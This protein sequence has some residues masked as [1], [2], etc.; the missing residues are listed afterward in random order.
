MQKKGRIIKPKFQHGRIVVCERTF[1]PMATPTSLTGMALLGIM[2]RPKD[3]EE[4]NNFIFC[5]GF[6]QAMYSRDI[7]GRIDITNHSQHAIF[8]IEVK[9]HERSKGYGTVLMNAGADHCRRAGVTTMTGEFGMAGQVDKRERFYERL[10]MPVKDLVLP[11]IS[12]NVNN[13]KLNTIKFEHDKNATEILNS[14]PEL[15]RFT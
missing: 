11:T 13:P 5:E 3:E 10:D 14:I 8:N 4:E 12:T 1:D 7:F 15:K 6:H 2:K 9:P